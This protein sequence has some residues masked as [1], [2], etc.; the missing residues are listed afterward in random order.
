MDYTC[1]IT[2][3]TPTYNRART[4][5]RVFHSLMNQTC[6]DFEWLIIDDGS[7]DHTG[8]VVASFK[9]KSDFEIRY[10][11][12]ENGGRHTAVNASYNK[13]RTPYVVTCDSDNELTPNA[14]ERMIHTWASI[15]PEDY[16]RYWCVTGREKDSLKGKM[17]GTPFPEYINALSGVKKRKEI[18]RHPGEKHCCRKTK[19]HIQYPFPVYK[20]TKFVTENIVW[21]K[22][23]KVYDQYCVNDIYGIYHTESED[24]L[25]NK[26]KEFTRERFRSGY[27]A[28]LFYVNEMFHE[29]FF[30]RSVI[31]AVINLSRCAI[32]TGQSY[33]ATMKEINKWYKKLL[34]TAGGGISYLWIFTHPYQ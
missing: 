22:I 13:F 32:L 4:L 20:D 6:K 25:T 11:W 16:D 26:K 19:I 28:S 7:T 8:Q 24:S 23:N 34:V 14:I 31:L 30:N 12:K 29:L 10:Y 21:E 3:F 15:P 1:T 5:P 2:V 27:Y 18:L 9:K 17:V 33:A